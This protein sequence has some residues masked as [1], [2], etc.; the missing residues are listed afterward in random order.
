M[1]RQLLRSTLSTLCLALCSAV[2]A[3]ERI[4]IPESGY[5]VFDGSTLAENVYGFESDEQARS[6]L[7][8]VMQHT[9]LEA[10]F[11][12]QAANVPN[13]VAA[14]QGAQRLILYN[15]AF[16]RGI[17]DNTNTDWSLLSVLAHEVGHHLQGHTLL[18]G[19]SRP[20]LEL[21]ADK[22]SGFILQRMGA[23]IDEAQAVTRTLP[24]A[25]SRTHPERS[26]RLAAVLNGWTQAEELLG[27]IEAESDPPSEEPVRQPSDP[28]QPTSTP[29]PQSQ[30]TLRAVFTGDPVA[31]FVTASDDIVAV[32]PQTRQP[33]L[34]GRK[35]PP[36]AP[37]FV[38]MYSTNYIT[39][40]VTNDGRIMSRDAFGRHFRVGYV[41]N[42]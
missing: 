5:C 2:T 19:G 31:Y 30:P 25:G 9:G 26:A 14:L 39:Y 24:E 35:I 12:L 34:V 29:S 36:T 11:V 7:Q 38:W 42:P 10:N 32:N 13:A 15:Q 33:V 17:L 8:R 20:A 28:V 27:S 40:G 21:Q 22:Y 18:P 37:G 16:M 41:T 4:E 3:Q 23:T 1:P 6:A